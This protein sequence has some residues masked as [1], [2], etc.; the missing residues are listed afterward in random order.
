MTEIPTKHPSPQA[1]FVIPARL[2]AS[3]LPRKPL[4]DIGGK[5]MIVH[6]WE[7]ACQGATGPVIVAAGD[8]EIVEVITAV[9]GIGVLTDPDLPSGSDRVYAAALAFDP[10][11]QFQIIVNVQGDMPL[12]DPDLIAQVVRPL[13]DPRLQVATLA[14]P[15]KEGERDRPSVVKIALTEEPGT[16]WAWAHYFS[17]SPIPYGDPAGWAHMG[18]YAYRRSALKQFVSLPRSPLE[19]AESLEQLRALEAGLKIGVQLVDNHAPQEVNTPEDLEIVR[20]LVTNA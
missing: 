20:R 4:A 15:V 11:S 17:R 2:A 5:P 3:R 1:L 19:K 8:P 9:G 6:V 7:R 14:T 18:L 10:E 16:S 13:S 12:V